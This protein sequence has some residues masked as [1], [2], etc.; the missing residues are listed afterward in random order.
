MTPPCD[1]CKHAHMRAGRVRGD[2][3]KSR[4]PRLWPRPSR[5]SS[6]APSAAHRF[7]VSRI[8]TP[9]ACS[10]G[11]EAQGP[12]PAVVP[13]SVARRWPLCQERGGRSV[14]SH[15]AIP[16]GSWMLASRSPE[17]TPVTHQS[18]GAA[19]TTGH[20]RSRPSPRTRTLTRCAG[21]RQ[22]R[23]SVRFDRVG[24][25]LEIVCG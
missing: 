13:M 8:R 3:R 14:V 7:R 17:R 10:Y 16:A 24:G 11:S 22:H 2:T 18:Y 5:M 23:R 19:G 25:T 1:M 6:A 9:V 20:T 15:R 4:C 12:M 21:R